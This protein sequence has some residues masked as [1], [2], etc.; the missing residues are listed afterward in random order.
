[1]VL[2][3]H[4]YILNHIKIRK[5]K[6]KH[7]LLLFLFVSLILI[8]S[9]CDNKSSSETRDFEAT[10][11]TDLESITPDSLT[12]SSPMTHRNIQVGEGSELNLGSFTT[13]MAFCVNVEDN[14]YGNIDAFMANSS[15][16]TIFLDG[17]GKVI[18]T[19]TK[20]GYDMEFKDPFTI[21]GG[22]GKF[23]GATGS[24]ITDS[25]VNAETNRTDHIWK[26]SITIKKK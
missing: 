2:V 8:F 6:L 23:S 4:T 10:F 18:P 1:M 13:I 14:S 9:N 3:R 12:C 15:G 21:I 24:G 17:G 20:E 25:Y 7:N 11:F 22:T 16:D 19:T 5:M 26:G